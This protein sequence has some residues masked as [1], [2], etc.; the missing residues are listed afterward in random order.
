MAESFSGHP[1][2]A[3]ESFETFHRHMNNLAVVEIFFP[4]NFSDDQLNSSRRPHHQVH[5]PLI[6][7]LEG[8]LAPANP[9]HAF[10]FSSGNHHGSVCGWL[11]GYQISPSV[12]PAATRPFNYPTLTFEPCNSVFQ[13]LFCL[14]TF[15]SRFLCLSSLISSRSKGVLW[16]IKPSSIPEQ[17]FSWKGGPFRC[18]ILFFWYFSDV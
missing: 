9:P 17:C 18:N 2:F 14:T 5:R 13:T 3:I 7:P 12:S 16:I 8:T 11:F 15:F 1:T 4:V 10:S 6:Y